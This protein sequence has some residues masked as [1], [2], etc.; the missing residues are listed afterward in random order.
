M[1]LDILITWG[2]YPHLNQNT[3]ILSYVHFMKINELLG[4]QNP[5]VSYNH[6]YF[7][8][9]WRIGDTIGYCTYIL[10]NRGKYDIEPPIIMTESKMGGLLDELNKIS[11]IMEGDLDKIQSWIREDSLLRIQDYMGG[12]RNLPSHP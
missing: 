9:E 5:Q 1:G 2:D 12:L 6:P 7:I 4:K 3:D 8:V 11:P 10:L